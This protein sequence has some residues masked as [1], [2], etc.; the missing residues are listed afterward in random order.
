MLLYSLNSQ[1]DRYKIAAGL[2]HHLIKRSEM[3]EV[4]ESDGE[5]QKTKNTYVISRFFILKGFW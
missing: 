1:Q 3:N 4:D 2:I 5:S